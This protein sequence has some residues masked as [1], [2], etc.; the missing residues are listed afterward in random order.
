MFYAQEPSTTLRLGDVLLGFISSTT[1]IGKAE[2]GK[3]QRNYQLDIA[4]S[5]YCAVL[6]PCCSIRGSI[7]SLAPLIQ[8]PGNVFLNPF[9]SAELTRIN[10]PVPPENELTPAKWEELTG[11]QRDARIARG[12][13]YTIVDRFV[14]D[15]HPLFPPYDVRSTGGLRV[16]TT[17]YMV[18]FK[19]IFRVECSL[20]VA[21]EAKAME[22][23]VPARK[24]LREKLAWYYA[25]IPDEDH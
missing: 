5:D 13:V 24:D 9:F 10:R 22:L 4:S 7:L 15:A 11:D 3:D 1:K 23:S 6:V 19:D 14:Y 17:C 18:S 20:A 12:S 25:R 16:K 2:F 21:Q 8:V